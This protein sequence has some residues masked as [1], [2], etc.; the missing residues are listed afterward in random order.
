MAP[1]RSWPEVERTSQFDRR[2]EDGPATIVLKGSHHLL[3]SRAR[4]K[5]NFFGD[6]EVEILRQQYG[7][8]PLTCSAPVGSLVF[9]DS[10]ALHLGRRSRHSRD[11]FQVNC[12]TKRSHLWPHE[13]DRNVLSSLDI[14]DQKSLLR[15]ADLS[16]I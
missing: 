13:I 9:F 14:E 11:V 7:W 10:Q 4:R 15:R 6:P 8:E 5:R 16:V 3:Y 1:R 12:M 2:V